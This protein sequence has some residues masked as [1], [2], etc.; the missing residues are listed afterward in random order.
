MCKNY[1]SHWLK[2]D[3]QVKSD[4]EQSEQYPAKKFGTRSQSTKNSKAY[5]IKDEIVKKYEVI[6]KN[7]YESRNLLKAPQTA[8]TARISR[9]FDQ[10]NIANQKKRSPSASQRNPQDL[11]AKDNREFETRDKNKGYFQKYFTAESTEQ[12]NKFEYDE[13]MKSSN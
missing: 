13:P 7:T 2:V 10:N 12:K 1:V 8:K 9:D 4:N 6:T 11:T 5:T 3:S